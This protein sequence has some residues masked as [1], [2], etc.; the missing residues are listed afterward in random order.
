MYTGTD[1]CQIKRLAHRLVPIYMEC[2]AGD[3]LYQT[4]FATFVNDSLGWEGLVAEWIGECTLNPLGFSP[5]W[6]ELGSHL[7]NP[8]S[9]Y[10]C[11]GGF[12]TGFFIVRP[13]V[14]NDWLDISEIFLT[15]S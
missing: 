2:E 1:A 6:F 11:P 3:N 14:M 13:S 8:S 4:C 12:S 5:L 10:G 15:E 9:A 7:G